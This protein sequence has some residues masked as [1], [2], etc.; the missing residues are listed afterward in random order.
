MRVRRWEGDE[1]YACP[2]SQRETETSIFKAADF[3][4][5]LLCNS[6]RLIFI[7]TNNLI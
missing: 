3:N 7:R 6:I 4:L 2:L 1:L 5:V